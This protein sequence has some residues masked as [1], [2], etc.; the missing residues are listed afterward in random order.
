MRGWR[1]SNDLKRQGN[2]REDIMKFQNRKGYPSG[3]L[4]IA[5]SLFPISKDWKFPTKQLRDCSLFVLHILQQREIGEVMHY[6]ASFKV[7][8]N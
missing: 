6:V 7:V 8:E 3:S 5:H 1:N 4:E 2:I